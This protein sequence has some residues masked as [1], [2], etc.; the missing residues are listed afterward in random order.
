MKLKLGKMTS[1]EIALWLNLTYDTYRRR[2]D[3]YLTRLEPYANYEK[4]YGGV[5]IKEIFISEYNK[6][7]SISDDI[8]YIREV[9]CANEGL[10]S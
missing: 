6:D 8:L 5:I 10:S 7:L 3:F 1:K 2:I 4:V 9:K